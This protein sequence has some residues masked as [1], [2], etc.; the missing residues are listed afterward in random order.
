MRARYVDLK[1]PVTVGGGDCI[2]NATIS[3]W[4]SYIMNLDNH[5]EE[6]FFNSHCK[7]EV[8]NGF[9]VAFWHS[10]WHKDGRMKLL[11]PA[12]FGTSLFQDASIAAMG[13]WR[14]DIWSWGDFG[15][16]AIWRV[17]LD[18]AEDFNKL[19][20]MLQNLFPMDSCS[21]DNVIWNNIEGDVF[22]VDDC[23]RKMVLLRILNG[24]QEKFN[25]VLHA[26]WR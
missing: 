8:G 11:F 5:V 7:F 14:N 23:H 22:K 6:G 25:S 26:V 17:N 12:L 4:W 13:G 20:L 21:S 3:T 2:R 15:V 10:H 9:G 24:P 16:K 19:N 18:M 1:I